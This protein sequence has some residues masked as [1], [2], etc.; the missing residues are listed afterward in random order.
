MIFPTTSNVNGKQGI[1]AIPFNRILLNYALSQGLKMW[2]VK[3]RRKVLA[4]YE[5]FIAN[6]N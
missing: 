5:L 6:K 1:P 3:Q 2:D 4:N